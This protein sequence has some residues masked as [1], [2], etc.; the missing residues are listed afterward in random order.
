MKSMDVSY[1]GEFFSFI[2]G[3]V[4][5][6]F[7]NVAILR[8]NTGERISTGRSRCFE[9]GKDLRWYELIPLL[10]FLIQKGKCRRCKSRISWQYFIVELVAGI[11]F[12]LTYLKW[13]SEYGARGD[14][15]ILI[16][17]L[18]LEWLLLV[19]S[20]YDFRHKIIS[21][22]YSYF[23]AAL[24]LFGAFVF[25]E[26]NL[27]AALYSII[28]AAFLFLL[29]VIS[30]GRWIGLGD[31]KLFLGAGFFL[32]LKGAISALIL[33]FWIGAVFGILLLFF[34]KKISLKAEVPFGP[35]LSL[36]IMVI[37]FFPRFFDFTFNAFLV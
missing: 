33:S 6:S 14:I 11:A 22:A 7:A 27:S 29:W 26:T 34:K 18:L 35:F 36:G 1:L 23:F 19:I 31:S 17:W 21:D 28:P 37:F 32:G 30:N 25:L 20:V 13:A 2:F 10:S 5:G 9:C 4:F 12:L 8:Q 3:L 16:W 15:R 24:A